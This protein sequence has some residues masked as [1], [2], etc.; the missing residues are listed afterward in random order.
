MEECLHRQW[1]RV[2]EEEEEEE[3]NNGVAKGEDNDGE[4]RVADQLAGS[5]TVAEEEEEETWIELGWKLHASMTSIRMR[6]NNSYNLQNK[7]LKVL[8]AN[9]SAHVLNVSIGDDRH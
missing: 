7:M 1:W 6:L 8:G 2:E 3:T 5:H 4:R 9:F